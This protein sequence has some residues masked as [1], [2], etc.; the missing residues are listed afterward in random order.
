MTVNIP[1]NSV[2]LVASRINNSSVTYHL[3]VLSERSSLMA[4]FRVAETFDN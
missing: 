1:T 3:T 4:N 2:R